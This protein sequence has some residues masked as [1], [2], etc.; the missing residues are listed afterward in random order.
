MF[1]CKELETL[2][3]LKKIALKIDS[4]WG[5]Y[6]W[7]KKMLKMSPIVTCQILTWSPKKEPP[8]SQK[9][10]LTITYKKVAFKWITFVK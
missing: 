3:C 8:F 10:P 4:R 2:G 9:E 1:G 6:A 7:S 5:S